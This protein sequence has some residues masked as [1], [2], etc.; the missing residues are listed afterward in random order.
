MESETP[1]LR[2]RAARPEEAEPLTALIMRSKAHWGYESA[3]LDAWRADLTMTPGFIASHY[4]FCAEDT[5][6]GA[7]LG[8]ASVF[9]LSDGELYLEHL[10][11]EPSAMGSGVGAALWRHAVAW[12]EEHGAQAITLGADPNA[13]SFYEHMGAVVVDWLDSDVVPGRRQPEMRYELPPR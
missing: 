13:R 9:P 1:A 7:T 3:L 10:F 8:V 12:A 4:T 5:A 6:T 11:V 2:I